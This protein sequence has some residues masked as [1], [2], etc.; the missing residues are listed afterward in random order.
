MAPA[1]A[2]LVALA[3]RREHDALVEEALRL[4]RVQVGNPEAHRKLAAA[5]RRMLVIETERRA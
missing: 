4:R 2:D 5:V 3:N 1:T